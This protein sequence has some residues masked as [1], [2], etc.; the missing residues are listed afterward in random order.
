MEARA[1]E[2]RVRAAIARAFAAV[3]F[4]TRQP[5]LRAPE[6][7]EPLETYLPA[8]PLLTRDKLRPTL[9]KAWFPADRDAKAELAAGKIAIVESGIGDARARLLFDAAAHRRDELRALAIH[10]GARAMLERPI[11]DAVLSVPT[12]GTGSC[13]SGDPTYEERLEGTC[14]HLNSR[15]DPAFWTPPVMTR[16]LDELESH[17]TDA[18]F[19]D[20]FYLATLADHARSVG[21]RLDVR[22]FVATTRSRATLAHRA[23]FAR[24]FDASRIVDV[25]GS[26]AAGT[27]FV[28]AEDGTMHHAPW[29]SH[30][31]LLAAKVATPGADRLALVV[32]TTLER[33]VQ[34]LV[35]FVLG[36]MVSVADG[37][38]AISPVASIRSVE[39]RFDDAIV[40]P[41]GGLVTAGALDRAIGPEPRGYQVVQTDPVSVEVEV[42]SGSPSSVRDAIAPLLAGMKIEARSTTAIGIEPNGKY[43]TTRRKVPL[44]L[45]NVFEGCEGVQR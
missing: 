25:Y 16:M 30:V 31:E 36:D 8:L 13:G 45:A 22:G 6:P 17:A 21:R 9:P 32:V 37:R 19:A 23:A 28:G 29:G 15:Q 34:P 38:S 42:V 24:V 12:R 1:H 20:P 4:Y 5:S 39:G 40:R 33:D 11:R 2:D 27:L 41:D 14:L 44:D 18:L 7:S 10:P 35:R 43:R 26:R 3:P